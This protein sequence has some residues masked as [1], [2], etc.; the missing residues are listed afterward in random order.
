[1]YKRGLADQTPNERNN[2]KSTQSN[3]LLKK[4][5]LFRSG[6]LDPS[7]CATRG[8]M[9]VEKPIPND[10]ATKTKLFP[11][12]T[13]ASSAVPNCP[14]MILSTSCTIVCPIRPTITGDA[15]LILYRNSRVYCL[16]F[17]SCFLL[18]GD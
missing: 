12:E 2:P 10:M 13:A 4:M 14:T 3:R 11:K 15:S 8:V 18:R 6:S 7:A 9:A 1:M 5:L 16:K 17:N